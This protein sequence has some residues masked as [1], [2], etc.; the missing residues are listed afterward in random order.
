MEKQKVTYTV[1]DSNKVGTVEAM[2]RRILV[3]KLIA[4]NTQGK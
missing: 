1:V 4:G 3:E 2:L